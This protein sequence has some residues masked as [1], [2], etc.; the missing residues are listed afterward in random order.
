MN[1]IVTYNLT[2]YF[3]SG[4][5][6]DN[7]QNCLSSFAFCHTLLV[8]TYALSAASLF[9][10]QGTTS[11]FLKKKS[12]WAQCR[13]STF[14]PKHSVSPNIVLTIRFPPFSRLVGSSRLELP[15]SRLSGARS[16]HLSYEPMSVAVRCHLGQ[17][18]WTGVLLFLIP[19]LLPLRF[20]VFGTRSARRQPWWR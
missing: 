11:A 12:W 13:S 9:S 4:S 7:P 19:R 17:P 16:N 10:F 6:P 18:V 14:A 8:I 2:N 3:S 20:V 1:C 15:T 5:Y